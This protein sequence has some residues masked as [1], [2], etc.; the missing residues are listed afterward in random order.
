LKIILKHYYFR[1]TAQLYILFEL[2]TKVRFV[3]WLL[4]AEIHG[5]LLAIIKLYDYQLRQ[6]K[7]SIK[8][9]EIFFLN[10]ADTIIGPVRLLKK[11]VW[12][13]QTKPIAVT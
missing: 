8:M 10:T 13:L 1:A 5:L 12:P 6:L 9:L 11:G 2:K 7:K 3:I 4:I